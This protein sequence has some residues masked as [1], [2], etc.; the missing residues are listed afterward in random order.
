[1]AGAADFPADEFAHRLEPAQQAMHDAN[2]DALWFTTEAEVRYFTG[3]RTLFWQSPTRPWHLVV[4]R[5]GKPIAVIPEIGAALMQASWI[6]DI[7]TWPSPAPDDDGVSLLAS[8][9]AAYGRVGIPMGPESMLRMPLADFQRVCNLTPGMERVDVTPLMRRLRMV[10]S[11]REIQTIREICGIASAAFAEA[12]VL[13]HAGQSLTG[14][15]RAFKL[16]LLRLG[17][18]DVPYLVGGAGPDGYVDVISPP[19][20]QELA[21]GDVLMLDIGASLRGYFCDF[22]RNFA[23]GR[24]SDAACQA[25]R[26]LWKATEEALN[27]ARPGIRACDL[28]RIMAGVIGQ[29]GGDVGRMGH[30]LGMQLTEPPSLAAFD[31]AVLEAGMVIT[32][33]PSMAVG[34]GRMLVTE[35][36]IVIRDGPPELLS[37]R[38]PEHLPVI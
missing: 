22:D 1:M 19:D 24:A 21:A 12:P 31:D 17:A 34:E 8:V 9:L 32:L 14:T 36:N 15:F 28:H 10:K 25:Y 38:A 16:A 2:L 30:G 23:I 11:E 33:E 26:T 6:E 37:R 4:P 27:A 3:F 5:R 35:E 29:D 18:E 13:F 20:G 7:R